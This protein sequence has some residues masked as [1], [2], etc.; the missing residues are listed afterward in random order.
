MSESTV[1]LIEQPRYGCAI[2][3]QQTVLAIPGALPILHAGPGCAE[4]AYAFSAQ[5]AGFQGEGYGGGAHITSSNMGEQDVV[6]GG[7]NKLRQNIQGALKILKGELYAVLTGCTADIV[8]DDSVSVAK[9]FA[10]KGYPVIGVET[11][12]FKGSNYYGHEAV[13]EAIIEQFTGKRLPQVKKGL[14]NVFSSVPFQDPFWR[15]DLEEV[16]RLLSALG[17]EVHVLFGSSSSG[18]C[19]WKALPDA[20]LNLLL[21]PWVGLKTV[22]LLE[23]RYGTPFFQYP[24]LPVGAEETSDFLRTIAKIVDREQEAERLIVKEESRFYDYFISVSDFISEFQNKIPEVF[25]LIADSHYA[26]GIST[27]LLRELGIL[28]GNIYITDNPTAEVQK[29]IYQNLREQGEE[30]D[31]HIQFEVDGGLIERD[32]K[33]SLQNDARAIILGS[34]W[35]K[36]IA[37]DYG[38]QYLYL[39]LPIN[40]RVITNR[41]YVGY[42]GGLALIEDIYTS[43]FQ[44]GTIVR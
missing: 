14:V 30:F 16:K 28:P 24:M 18:T 5:G 39:S 32:L 13:L 40:E 36:F 17:L 38:A 34:S 29:A 35:E 6:F 41:S 19:E 20:E 3:A 37:Q 22:K 9:E 2:A 26:V 8:G 44:K 43:L 21:S 12:G 1:K 31:G 42:N 15:G 11:A 25:Y 23:K 7:E 10:E 4:K 27:F 33:K